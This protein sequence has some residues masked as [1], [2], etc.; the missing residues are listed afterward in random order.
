M[1]RFL[2][3][4]GRK[5]SGVVLYDACDAEMVESTR[6]HMSNG[7]A[8]CSRYTSEGRHTTRKMHREMFGGDALDARIEVD[9]VNGCKTDNRRSN[10][11][12]VDRSQNCRNVPKRKG[13]SSRFKGVSW[14]VP[15]KGQG[16]PKWQAYA[17]VNG[18]RQFLGSFHSEEEAAAAAAPYYQTDYHNRL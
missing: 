15:P 18:A 9:H 1:I 13:T 5:H 10:L 17:R 6:W 11:R 4:L 16:R 8:V 2:H 12:L 14:R 3:I 7:Y